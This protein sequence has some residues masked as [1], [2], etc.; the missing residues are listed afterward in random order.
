MDLPG[1][2]L[3]A[4]QAHW[5]RALN[6]GGVC[7]FARNITT[8]EATARLVADIRSALERDVLIATDQEGGAVLRRL[9]G[10]QPPPPGPGRAGR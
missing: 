7:L 10:P 2:A 3:T 9:D 1:A 6:P 8:P 4:A 5:L